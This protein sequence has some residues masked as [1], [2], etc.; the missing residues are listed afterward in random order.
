MFLVMNAK[1]FLDTL[2][3]ITKREEYNSICKSMR[4]VVNS[5]GDQYSNNII[6]NPTTVTGTGKAMGVNPYPYIG[7][8]I[9]PIDAS[10]VP[11]FVPLAPVTVSDSTNW[12]GGFQ[13]N[14]LDAFLD[15]QYLHVDGARCAVTGREI[16]R[17]EPVLI[18][19][20]HIISKEAFK[21]MLCNQFEK[22]M[23]DMSEMHE[24]MDYNN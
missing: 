3:T 24:Q 18:L 15:I 8:P 9:P 23:F 13:V 2:E 19:F 22:M 11:P 21:K 20:E 12:P 7:D 10:W 16:K 17:G 6:Y 5:V 14:A 1:Q 4:Q